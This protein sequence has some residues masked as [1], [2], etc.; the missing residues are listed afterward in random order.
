MSVTA[1]PPTIS[2]G[3]SKNCN[4]KAVGAVSTYC[5]VYSRSYATAAREANKQQPLLGNGSV[6]TFPRQRIRTQ[7]YRYCWKR[8]FYSVCAKELQRRQLG[9]W[10][11]KYFHR[12]PASLRRR[13]KENPMSGGTTGPPYSWGI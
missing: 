2:C 12:S 9:R 7:R 1:Q 11:V 3:T 5:S 10:G 6:N 13:R 4:A 8:C